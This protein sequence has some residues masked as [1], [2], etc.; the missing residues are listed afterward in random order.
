MTSHSTPSSSTS[1]ISYPA[2]DPPVIL[3]EDYT[4]NGRPTSSSRSFLSSTPAP[5]STI[6]VHTLQ[7]E[8]QL[9]VKLP[10]FSWDGITL[11]TK[12]RRILHVVADRWDHGGGHFERR[13]AFGYDADLTQV[14]A[15]FHSDLLR[16][17]IP[18]RTSAVSS[19]HSTVYAP[20][21]RSS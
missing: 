2:P 5:G 9:H 19:L 6:E 13:V 20:I 12:R 18:R 16:V 15:D 11:A 7:H 3:P 1:S 21:G 17:T 8:Y 4:D 10:G 14:K